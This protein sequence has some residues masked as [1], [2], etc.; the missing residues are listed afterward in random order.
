[1]KKYIAALL[2][3][4]F[5]TAFQ[6]NKDISPQTDILISVAYGETQCAD[7]W[8]RGTTDLQTLRNIEEFMREKGIRFTGLEI[9]AAPRDLIVCLACTCPSGRTIIGNVHK[10]DLSKIEQYK[11]VRRN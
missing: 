10:D 8:Q 2:L 11:F 1:M 7:P 5:A 4:I 3:L 9:L 6:C